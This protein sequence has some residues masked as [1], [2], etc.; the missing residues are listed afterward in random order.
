VGWVVRARDR[1]NYYGMKFKVV[2]PGLRP[3]I[4]MVHFTVLRGKA[5]R[6][7]ETPLSVMVHNNEPY[8]VAVEVRGNRV[9]TSIEGQEIDSYADNT[10]AS[11]GVGFFADAGARARL[12]WMRVTANDDFVGKV[13]AYV[14]SALGQAPP[15]TA[16]V[17]AGEAPCGAPGPC[18][19]RGEV[20]LA[21]ALAFRKSRKG[22]PWT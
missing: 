8:H 4:A 12:Y 18:E 2:E 10:L 3:I 6:E 14:A 17:E 20:A 16:Q 7:V 21:A 22:K 15:T 13:C 19:P 11:G 5:G 9:V 1:K